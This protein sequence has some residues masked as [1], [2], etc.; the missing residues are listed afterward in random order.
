M[1]DGCIESIAP[2]GWSTV[3][4]DRVGLPALVNGNR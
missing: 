1:P 3:L 2:T 4:T